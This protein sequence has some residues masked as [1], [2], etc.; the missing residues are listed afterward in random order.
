MHRPG[1]FHGPLAGGGVAGATATA[2]IHVQQ[3]LRSCWKHRGAEGREKVL[4]SIGCLLIKHWSHEVAQPLVTCAALTT[5]RK[6]TRWKNLEETVLF[7]LIILFLT[8]NS[9]ISWSSR[10]QPPGICGIWR[11]ETSHT[12]LLTMKRFASRNSGIV[13]CSCGCMCTFYCENENIQ[14]KGS[15]SRS[16]MACFCH[17]LHLPP[18]PYQA[19]TFLRLCWLF[20]GCGSP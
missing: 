15:R 18:K 3:D 6:R 8:T 1:I 12:S 17:Y 4:G 9:Y 19:S 14:N 20:L 10:L 11:S 5:F 16:D 7:H 13:F 2:A